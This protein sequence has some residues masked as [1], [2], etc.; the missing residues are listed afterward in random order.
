MQT[1]MLHFQP[2]LMPITMAQPVATAAP[3]TVPAPPVTTASI[4]SGSLQPLGTYRVS[5]TSPMAY[6]VSSYIVESKPAQPLVT[7]APGVQ[8][9]TT[10]R[11]DQAGCWQGFTVHGKLKGRCV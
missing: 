10:S 8:V 11:S 5:T 4:S 1:N 2:P 7:Q 6:P 3:V 9:A